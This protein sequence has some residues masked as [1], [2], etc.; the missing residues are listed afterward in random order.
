LANIDEIKY[1][2]F[3]SINF[4]TS[5]WSIAVEE[6]F[7]VVWGLIGLL[8]LRHM[9]PKNQVVKFFIF[10]LLVISL[11][12]RLAHVADTRVLYYHTL[13]VM[14]DLLMGCLLAVL[15]YEN[16]AF[17]QKAR[18]WKPWQSFSVYLIGFSIILFKNLI[19]QGVFQVAE[20]YV[21][22]LFFAFIIL[23]Q[24]VHRRKFPST[25]LHAMALRLGKISYGLYMYHLVVLYLVNKYVFSHLNFSERAMLFY[26]FAAFCYVLVSWLLVVLLSKLSYRFFER[27]FLKL[28]DRW[29]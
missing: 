9:F 6:Q 1:G 4:L 20:R 24:I 21:I 10:G 17:F 12:F 16:P 14:P 18:L 15:W 27:P 2:A 23:D 19:F 3:D 25:V 29:G 5:P 8:F 7:Y 28:K 22:A 11:F 13:S 26:G